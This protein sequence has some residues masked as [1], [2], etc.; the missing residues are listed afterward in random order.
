MKIIKKQNGGQY[1]LPVNNAN[2]FA[3]DGFERIIIFGADEGLS[4][5]KNNKHW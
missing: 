5:L 2:F 1:S 3:V 4:F